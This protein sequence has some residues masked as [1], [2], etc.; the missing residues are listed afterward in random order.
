MGFL[1]GMASSEFGSCIDDCSLG[2][3]VKTL[4][5]GPKPLELMRYSAFYI[6]LGSI[7]RYMNMAL[8]S[9]LE[10][11]YNRILVIE[12]LPSPR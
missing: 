5:R 8:Y 1:L 6:V 2:D 3:Q 4:S 11:K 10:S 12:S 9:L 7:V